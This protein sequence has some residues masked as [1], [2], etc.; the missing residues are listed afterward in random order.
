MYNL[1][2]YNQFYSNVFRARNR[3]KAEETFDRLPKSVREKLNKNHVMMCDSAYTILNY[4]PKK[5][6]IPL[7]FFDRKS[8]LIDLIP[9]STWELSDDALIGVMAHETAHAYIKISNPIIKKIMIMIFT[10]RFSRLSEE[11]QK[12]Y[13]KPGELYANAVACKWGFHKEIDSVDTERQIKNE[14]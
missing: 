9:E 14:I 2:K 10:Y 5:P 3:I 7:G 13:I 4:D 8:K 1:T 6:G 11:K 12:F